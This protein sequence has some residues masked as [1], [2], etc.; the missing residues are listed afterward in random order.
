MIY[1]AGTGREA[2]E[3]LGK[4]ATVEDSGERA[5]VDEPG[6]LIDT[7]DAKILLDLG[8]RAGPGEAVDVCYDDICRNGGRGCGAT[9]CLHELLDT[10]CAVANHAKGG[11]VGPQIA[12]EV[13]APA[14]GELF[15]E[16]RV[17][18]DIANVVEAL[19]TVRSNLPAV[20]IGGAIG[21]GRKPCPRRV[22][23]PYQALVLTILLIRRA[24]DFP[25]SARDAEVTL[26]ARRGAG[27]WTRSVRGAGCGGV[28]VTRRLIRGAAIL[29]ASG[30]S[31]LAVLVERAVVRDA[32]SR[33]VRVT[34]KDIAIGTAEV[35][36]GFA[37][38]GQAGAKDTMLPLWA[39]SFAALVTGAIIVAHG[40]AVAVA[41]GDSGAAEIR[42]AGGRTTIFE[43]IRRVPA[44]LEV[45]RSCPI[46]LT[47]ENTIAITEER[48]WLACLDFARA[49]PAYLAPR[50]TVLAFLMDGCAP[51]IWRAGADDV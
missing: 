45:T 4:W 18:I 48:V 15:S 21:F 3:D 30:R 16:A 43:A 42:N 38:D 46:V 10:L 28:A 2:L 36:P 47:S 1:R 41:G 32:G 34:Q 8:D 20:G 39:F 19:E 22:A 13:T 37:D 7:R 27:K 29:F 24:V 25:T 35:V 51:P 17:A 6:E 11:A 5:F 50:F 40:W 44:V 49:V 26:L 33:S 31:F 23:E 9:D 12:V 14:F